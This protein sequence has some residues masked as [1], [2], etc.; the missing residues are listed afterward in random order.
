M[1]FIFLI[2]S[3]F[4]KRCFEIL[5]ILYLDFSLTKLNGSTS[6]SAKL[7]SIQDRNLYSSIN[8]YDALQPTISA[9]MF[10]S[11]IESAPM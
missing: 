9:F 2:I 5:D 6:I 11:P 8:F 3:K 1:P 4:V 7:A 10:F